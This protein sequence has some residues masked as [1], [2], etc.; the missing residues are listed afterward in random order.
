VEYVHQGNASS[1]DI[2]KAKTDSSKNQ[3]PSKQGDIVN[4]EIESASNTVLP[5][6][7]WSEKGKARAFLRAKTRPQDSILL[8]APAQGQHPHSS[9]NRN[10]APIVGTFATAAPDHEDRQEQQEPEQRDEYDGP[11]LQTRTSTCW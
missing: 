5:P 2:L 6:W 9:A 10:G 8:V 1:G 4:A 3:K 11:Q 7:H